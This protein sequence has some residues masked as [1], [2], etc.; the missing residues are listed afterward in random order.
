MFNVGDLIKNKSFKGKVIATY[1]ARTPDDPPVW[2]LTEILY[3]SN[4][5]TYHIFSGA[6]ALTYDIGM[7]KENFLSGG[8][9]EVK[10]DKEYAW[11]VGYDHSIKRIT[12]YTSMMETE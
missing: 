7:H 4:Y 10:M 5:S 2:Y 11:I 1:Q 6:E 3:K 9:S 12:S 8:L